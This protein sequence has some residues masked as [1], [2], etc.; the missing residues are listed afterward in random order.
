MSILLLVILFIILLILLAIILCANKKYMG[1]MQSEDMPSSITEPLCEN[2]NGINICDPSI[3][4]LR[5]MNI[6]NNRKMYRMTINECNYYFNVD[7]TMKYILVLIDGVYC[8]IRLN[9]SIPN[10]NVSDIDYIKSTMHNY[11]TLSSAQKRNAMAEIKKKFIL[12]FTYNECPVLINLTNAKAELSK[13][14]E[15]LKAKCKGLRLELDYAYNMGCPM[16]SIV[17][18]IETITPTT[19]I[20]CLFNS[21]ECIS[22][23]IIS[24]EDENI[25]VINSS[26][27]DEF[28]GKKYNK[29]LR[30]VI[31][32]IAFDISD[33]ITTLRSNATNLV[34]AYLMITSFDAII[35]DAEEA[36]ENQVFFDFLENTGRHIDDIIDY[37]ALFIE[38]ES[39]A[40]N[41]F[42]LTVYCEI[43]VKD[44]TKLTTKFNDI[45]TELLC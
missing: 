17:S 37:K 12:H 16:T 13:L 27:K 10:L 44:I 32:L 2:V 19:L 3:F 4:D 45:L 14:N 1:G 29:L 23:I 15:L 39:A 35:L 34:S 31:I 25:M 21:I 40:P 33:Q 41:G 26:T 7:N 38:F 24:I 42:S 11:K 9:I 8:I 6:V 22:S 5:L 43:P 18:E 30:C 36:P 28:E 20:L